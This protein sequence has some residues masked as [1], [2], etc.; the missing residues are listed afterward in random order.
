MKKKTQQPPSP[1]LL[2]S[3]LLSSPLLSSLLVACFGRGSE[4]PA[5]YLLVHCKYYMSL[6]VVQC[7]LAITSTARVYYFR[8]RA[9]CLSPAMTYFQA[10][11]AAVSSQ[12]S[13]KSQTAVPVEQ[14]PR[15][16]TQMEMF[17][18]NNMCVIKA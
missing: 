10:A 6:T 18:Q 14:L 16:G 9:A 17:V 7:C 1:P 5:I 11:S 4:K 13:A 12:Q 3:P 15:K 8:K 2:S